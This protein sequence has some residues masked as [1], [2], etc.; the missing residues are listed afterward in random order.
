[1]AL[2]IVIVIRHVLAPHLGLQ[3]PRTRPFRSDPWPGHGARLPSLWR[4][5]EP[6][7]ATHR[8]WEAT[9]RATTWHT[10]CGAEVRTGVV[11]FGR[12]EGS[13]LGVFFFFFLN[14][15]G[16]QYSGYC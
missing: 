15:E 10:S 12:A 9:Q 14:K 3:T 8:R 11:L 1:M 16:I 4:R 5:L 7:G 6:D 2:E 13:G